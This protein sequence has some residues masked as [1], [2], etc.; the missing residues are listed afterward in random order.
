M[1]G[2]VVEVFGVRRSKECR[3][4][5]RWCNNDVKEV[6]EQKKIAYLR[7]LQQ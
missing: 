7:W 5:K 2:A 4:R 1:I 3:K 6:V